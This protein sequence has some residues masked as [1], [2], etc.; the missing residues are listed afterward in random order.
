MKRSNLKQRIRRS[1]AALLSTAMVVTSFAVP[2]PVMADNVREEVLRGEGDTNYIPNGEFEDGVD[3]WTV[4]GNDGIFNEWS[5][6]VKDDWGYAGSQSMGLTTINEASGVQS[7]YTEVDSLPAGTYEM[8]AYVYSWANEYDI[9]LFATGSIDDYE[10]IEAAGSNTT[11]SF[12]KITKT[13]EIESDMEGGVAGI[14]FA[15]DETDGSE[16][17]VDSVSLYRVESET[18]TE[19]RTIYY[20]YDNESLEEGQYLAVN[21]WS[22]GDLTPVSANAINVD[23]G[24]WTGT[25]Y[26]LTQVYASWW[27]LELSEVPAGG[28]DLYLVNSDDTADSKLAGY[29]DQWNN[30]DIF[31]A[32]TAEDNEVVAVDGDSFYVNDVAVAYTQQ[33]TMYIYDETEGMVPGLYLWADGGAWDVETYPLTYVSA[34]TKEITELETTVADGG[35]NLYALSDASDEVGTNWYKITF[36]ADLSKT[37]KAFTYDRYDGSGIEWN[38]GTDF[39]YDGS[40]GSDA[41][42]MVTEGKVYY[43]DGEFFASMEQEAA[44]HTLAQLRTLVADAGDLNKADYTAE[45]WEAVENALVSANEVLEKDEYKEVADEDAQDVT[46]EDIEDAYQVLSGAI[47]GLEN[48]FVADR[49]V[50]VYIY[51]D[52]DITGLYALPWGDVAEYFRSDEPLAAAD[53]DH[54]GWYTFDIG[55]VDAIK[56]VSAEESWPGFQIANSDWSGT[57][58]TFARGNGYDVYEA[59]VINSE[60]GD[61]L[62]V[63]DGAVYASYEDAETVSLSMLR[64]LVAT[65][66]GYEAS[67]YTEGSFAEFSAALVSANEIL[68]KDDYKGVSDDDA[69][70]VTGDDIKEA[71]NLLKACAEHLEKLFSADKTVQVYLYSQEDLSGLLVMAWESIKDYLKAGAVVSEAGEG[72]P[73]WYTFTMEMDDDIATVT[74]GQELWP[75]FTLADEGWTVQKDTFGEGTYYDLYKAMVID[76]KD[77]DTL[78]IKNGALYDSFEAAELTTLLML[79]ELVASVEDYEA[80]SYTQDSFDVFA[81]ALVSANEILSSGDYKDVTDDEA[82]EIEG[83]DIKAAYEGLK[84]AIDNLVRLFKADK[85][86]RVFYYSD[87]DWSGL[88]VKTWADIRDFMQDETPVSAVADHPGWYTFEL[89]MDD[90][91]ENVTD[92]GDKWPGFEINSKDWDNSVMT[93]ARGAT[94]DIYKALV[95]T[96]KDGDEFYVKDDKIYS[97]F[98]GADMITLDMLLDLIE[99]AELYNADDFSAESFDVLK[100]ALA[101]AKTYVENIEKEIEEED[102]EKTATLYNKLKDAI[103]ALKYSTEAGINVRKVALNDDFITGADLSSFVS[104]RQS[105]VVF[106]ADTNGD[107]VAEALSDQQFFN[108]LKDGGTNWVRIRIWNDP[109]DSSGNGYGGGNNDI[110]KAVILAKLAQNAGM[111]ILIDF[112]YSDFWADPAK[113]KAPKAW[114]DMTNQQKAD[115]LYKFTYESLETLHDAGIN[116]IYMVQVGNE[117]NHGIAGETDNDATILYGYGCEAVHDAADKLYGHYIDAAVHFTDVQNGG[118]TVTGCMDRQVRNR[119]YKSHADGTEQYVP[120]DAVGVSY[121]PMYNHGSISN[122]KTVLKALKAGYGPGGTPTKVYVA[123]T[124]WAWTWLDGDGFHNS[125]PSISGGQDVTSYS[126]SVQGQADELRAVVDAVNSVNEGKD[127]LS[128]FGVFYWESAWLSP[129]QACYDDYSYDAENYK[130]NVAAWETYGSGW[131]SKYS[132]EYDPTDAGLYYG[133]VGVDNMGWFNFDGTALDTAR[134]FKLIRSGA[135]AAKKEVVAVQGNQKIILNVGTDAEID[136]ILPATVPVYYNDGSEGETSVVW[137]KDEKKKIDLDEAGIYEING[138]AKAEGTV[139][140]VKLTVEVVANNSIGALKNNDFEN[141]QYNTNNNVKFYNWDVYGVNED[142]TYVTYITDT[143]GTDNTKYFNWGTNNITINNE[144]AKGDTQKG[145]AL[146]FWHGDA[147]MDIHIYQKIGTAKAGTEFIPGSYTF[148]GY[149]E[150]GSAGKYDKQYAVA[151][152][153]DDEAAFDKDLEAT[154]ADPVKHPLGTDAKRYKASTQFAGWLSWQE[155]KT[156]DIKVDA[157]QY[158]VVG[159]EMN[160]STAGAWGSVDDTYLYGTY[161][162]NVTE[163]T[164]NGQGLITASRYV[165]G[166]CEKVKLTAKSERGSMLNTITVTGEGVNETYFKKEFANG[167]SAWKV[168]GKKA[169]YTATEED[170]SLASATI[171]FNMPEGDVTVTGDFVNPFE[172]GAVDVNDKEV[173]V[174]L[175]GIS[176][177]KAAFYLNSKRVMPEV[178]V[179][180]RGYT[181]AEKDFKVKYGKNASV[182]EG[183][184]TV[185]GKK[186]N[187]TGS[188]NITFKIVDDTRKKIASVEFIRPDVNKKVKEYYYTGSPITFVDKAEDP[189]SIYA[190]EVKDSDGNTV[191]SNEYVLGYEKNK[192]VGKA[193]LYVSAVLG[194]AKY[195]GSISQKFKVQKADISKLIIEGDANSRMVVNDT[196][197]IADV[198]YVKDGAKPSVQIWYDKTVNLRNKKDYSVTYQNNKKVSTDTKKAKVVIKGKGNYKGKAVLTLNIK[199]Y[200]ITDSDMIVQTQDILEGKVLKPKTT[201][202]LKSSNNKKITPGLF[203]VSVYEVSANLVSANSVSVNQLGAEVTGQKADAS[204]NYVVRVDGK[205]ELTGTVIK[206]LR[207]ADKDHMVTS[208]SVKLGKVY[209]QAGAIR[210]DKN[211]KGTLRVDTIGNDTISANYISV[212]TGSGATILTQDQFDIYLYKQKAKDNITSAGTAVIYLRV[213]DGAKAADGKLL[214]GDVSK[215]FKVKTLKLVPLSKYRT[216][217]SANNAMGYA[218]I[219]HESANTPVQVTEKTNLFDVMDEDTTYGREQY[220]TGYKKTPGYSGASADSEGLRVL[221]NG[222]EASMPFIDYRLSYADNVKAS[223]LTSS[224]NGITYGGLNKED[225]IPYTYAKG[226]GVKAKFSGTTNY[227]GTVTFWDAFYIRPRTVDDLEIV[228]VN[229]V[230]FSG[231]TLLND[232]KYVKFIDPR[233]GVE[234]FMKRG[235]AYDLTVKNIKKVSGV[236]G[237]TVPNLVFTAKNDLKGTGNKNILKWNFALSSRKL[238]ESNTEIKEIKPQKYRNGEAVE[239]KLK[240]KC[241]KKTLRQNKDYVLVYSNNHDRCSTADAQGFEY[242]S[243]PTVKII[244]IGNYTGEL[245]RTFVIQ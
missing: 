74:E 52:D 146:N 123:E 49:T 235:T 209:Y 165:A 108:Y 236:F 143:D 20:R 116:D 48:L 102:A 5:P 137:N 148:G 196:N 19:T 202:M 94:Y 15:K 96:S 186:P 17:Y 162:I 41:S 76:S 171:Y 44:G 208:A 66:S 61:E 242:D 158:L 233:Y 14:A 161:N 63:K 21:P 27:K 214:A 177:D 124:S 168:D 142:G 25:G 226:E 153:Y 29:D 174:S 118:G 53:E 182:G 33:V 107:G 112:H 184:I 239:P 58:A 227:T 100:K 244:G 99:E 139:Y 31:A 144:N 59:L 6:W 154:K 170:N 125:G 110:N 127:D 91:I 104:V 205:K 230:Q 169:V 173:I 179:R 203:N 187:F 150:G 57:V 219:N 68:S 2:M 221:I 164:G 95:I 106:K 152:V 157:G 73:G 60:D 93:I 32:M 85:T 159:F 55:L 89:I 88:Y 204:K 7:V 78:Y 172:N 77:G 193:T 82:A 198:E 22:A 28:F 211:G 30:T 97:S 212:K 122:L 11:D 138:K 160:G 194:S 223:K 75:G 79:R 149:L 114:A 23:F 9:D 156:E 183:T 70:G 210:L 109:Y 1:L 54:L 101:E 51:S 232:V 200:D 10:F 178:T 71:Y 86:V 141:I 50:H 98:E 224:G 35:N 240:V 134:I 147:P 228:S 38:P 12:S 231:K 126:I 195:S 83:D 213:K 206:T 201:L 62:F 111:K 92:E 199:P 39:S 56:E 40:V 69:E 103:N 131:A 167:K 140:V 237:N 90:E 189:D 42:V 175:N 81:K 36:V 238:T 218:A 234:D 135:S 155:V 207:V 241:N 133:G 64:Q 3:G 243:A 192:K 145:H 197:R 46:G 217:V 185:T 45:S 87:T 136:D 105:G 84:S 72:H 166:T 8:T 245:T 215:K 18:E 128:A 188:K 13:F 151:Y 222:N 163:N 129:Y 113:Y 132:I 80:S 191:S 176:P 115:A 220:Y 37:G 225:P 190:I 16:I 34:E 4:S 121:Y 180:Y 119:K 67:S 117:S 130:K 43:K 120:Y 65:V 24:G 181:L 216:L 26:P 47:K 229:S